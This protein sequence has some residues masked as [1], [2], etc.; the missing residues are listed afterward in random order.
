MRDVP[1]EKLLSAAIERTEAEGL[2][3]T[4]ISLRYLK[5]DLTE[6]LQQRRRNDAGKILKFPEGTTADA[7]FR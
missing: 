4:S 3:Q 5:A 1:I 7:P 6:V 2:V